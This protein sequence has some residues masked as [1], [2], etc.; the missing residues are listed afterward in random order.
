MG[1]LD[2]LN[3]MQNGPRGQQQPK[4][5]GSSSGG[6][7]SP[8]MMA[9]LGLLAYKAL[10]G[11]GGQAAAPPGAGQPVPLRS[12]SHA[13]SASFNCRRYSSR[14]ARAARKVNSAVSSLRR[15]PKPTSDHRELTTD[16]I[17]PSPV[18]P[19]AART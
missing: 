1:L 5:S 18:P 19:P 10:K 8:I 7:M 17:L 2:I 4:S 6:G 13:A 12:S 15:C 9:L 16:F 11:R 3:G 14:S